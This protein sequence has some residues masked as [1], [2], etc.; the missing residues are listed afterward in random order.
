MIAAKPIEAIKP[1]RAG[2]AGKNY[3]PKIRCRT[4]INTL[5]K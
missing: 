3:A 5:R 2:F 1:W 4:L